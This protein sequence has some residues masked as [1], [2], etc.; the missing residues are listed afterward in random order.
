MADNQGYMTNAG[1]SQIT[2]GMD[3]YGVNGD[4][5]GSVES[6]GNDRF[7]VQKGLIF[8]KDLP[9]PFSAIRD[10]RSDGV[11]LSVTKDQV[12]NQDWSAL[13]T[14]G[15]TMG[16][17]MGQ[18]MTQRADVHGQ[19]A[20]TQAGARA[21]GATGATTDRGDIDIPLAEEELVANRERGQIGDVR[22]EKDVVS[23]QKTATAPV[24][25][26]EVTVDREPVNEPI[27]ADD[28][29]FQEREFDVP[30]M[31]EKV[32]F[33]KEAHVTEE[34]H[35]R[36]DQVTDQE[37]ATDT[38]RREQLRVEGDDDILRQQNQQQH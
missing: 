20:G 21:T 1:Y 24:T 15:A 30:V 37:Q 17:T 22:V 7:V 12:E 3:V 33:S 38:V 26:E 14:H 18:T 10:V 34:V 13:G 19:H 32:N 11:Y 35:L 16:Q 9:V 31:G 5:I 8:T 23:E 25:R 28:H 4:K 6:V 27:S 2:P 29:A 36:K